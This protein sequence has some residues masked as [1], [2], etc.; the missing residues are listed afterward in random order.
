[1]SSAGCR[2]ILKAMS[3]PNPP[4]LQGDEKPQIRNVKPL[5]PDI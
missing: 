2:F 4:A 3:T 5:T 1:M